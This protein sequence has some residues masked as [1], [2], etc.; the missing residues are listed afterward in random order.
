MK[1]ISADIVFPI[2]KPPVNN[3]III[4]DEDGTL[5]EEIINPATLDYSVS[6]VEKFE[7]FIC[8][9]FVNS[10]CHLELSWLKNK[11]PEH[12]GL[13]Q[14]IINLEN[15]RREGDDEKFDAIIAAEQEIINGGIV[16]VGDICNSNITFPVKQKSKLYY[17]NFIESFA[18]APEKAEKVFEK[19][20]LL[21][22]EI[23]SLEK[24]N[25]TSITPHA[26]Y[27]LSKK[28]FL[29]IKEHDEKTGNILSIHHQESEEE[30]KFFLTKK[31]N[32]KDMHF[33]FG[34]EHSDFS[35]CGKRPL[36]AISSYIAKNNPLQLVHNTVATEADIDFALSYFQ[37]IY[38]CFCPNANLYIE[39][40]LP[41]FALF[42]NKGCKI[43]IGTDSFASN[44]FLSVLEELKTI[45]NNMPFLPLHEMLKWATYNGAEF[46]GITE[47]YGSFEK[48]KSPGIILLEHVNFLSNNLTRNSSVK[49]IK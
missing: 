37:K 1:K 27:S 7:G 5:K 11:M 36:E 43:T 24:N 9:G 48:G 38:W 29:L 13:D 18:S 31:G 20:L 12:T 39:Q 49:V 45:R 28:L 23:M 3:G 44:K 34:V 35:D 26:P 32:I 21:Y 10:H 17:H 22:N 14:F 25:S 33:R 2:T 16:A 8:P 47:E 19:A 46:L 6:D 40:K 4:I 41:D 15:I 42:F 30:N